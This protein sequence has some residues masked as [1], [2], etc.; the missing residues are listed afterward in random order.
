MDRKLLGTLAGSSALGIGIGLQ[1]SQF[2]VLGEIMAD[3]HWYADSDIGILSGL[4]LAG[5]ILGCLHQTSI[6]HE[7]N[8]IRVVRIG[9]ALGVLSFFIEPL[10]DALSWQVLWRLIAGWSSAQL[11]TGIPGLGIRFHALDN[12][13][14]ALAYIFAGAGFAALLASVVVSLIASTSVVESWVVTGLIAVVLAIPIHNL[15][16]ICIEEELLKR[17]E[18]QQGSA[19]PSHQGLSP[20]AVASSWTKG[21]RLLA[22]S[23]LFFGAAQVTVLT[24]FPLLL[25]SR[26]NVSEAAAASSFA[27]VGLGYT[28]GALASGYM[29]RKWSTDMLMSASA[30]I[31]ILGTIACAAGSNIPAVGLG[32]FAF[33]FWN[34]S[35]MG[36]LLHRIN[37]SV[38]SAVARTTWS[39]FSL[40]L[41]VGFLVFTFI[42]APIANKNVDLIIWIGAVLAVLHLIFQLMARRDFNMRISQQPTN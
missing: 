13:R 25:V 40:I 27:N 12:K 36:L 6:K 9:L 16:D 34:G 14:R 8:N 41:S 22:G 35:M 5:Y 15:L 33:A 21:L 19:P 32:G 26:F 20:E 42:S 29:P 28:V 11:V 38:P 30:S 39:Q 10:I 1:R 7:L 24:Y 4:S 37:Q 17:F 31:G 3:K 23:T 18:Q 2:A